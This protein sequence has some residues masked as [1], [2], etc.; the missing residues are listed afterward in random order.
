AVLRADGG[1]TANRFLMQEQAD[2]L[3]IPVEVAAAR[4]TTALG[5]AMLAGLAVGVWKTPA[6]LRARRAIAGRYEPN[7]G[8]DERDSRYAQWTRAVDRARS[9]TAVSPA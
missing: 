7:I 9:W 1:G 2:I 3:G 6:E 4:E 5:A 8:K